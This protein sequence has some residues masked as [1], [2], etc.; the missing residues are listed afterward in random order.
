[1]LQ[2]ILTAGRTTTALA[3]RDKAGA[4]RALA[5]LFARDD[6]TLDAEEIY[7]VLS[8]RE[9][10][11]STGV[12]SG[13]AV[14]HGRLAGLGSIRAALG[15]CEHGVRFDAIDGDPVQV[16]VAILAPE[17]QPSQHLRVLAEVSRRLRDDA[18]RQAILGAD[19]AT[20]AMSALVGA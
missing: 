7:R 10:L 20:A 8:E 2:E 5:E 6:G 13:V 9:Q 15:V 4:L 14:P 11:A 1:M 16:F 12:G 18:V 19:D 3:A 17:D